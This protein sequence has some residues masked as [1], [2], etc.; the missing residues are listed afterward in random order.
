M[1]PRKVIFYVTI[2]SLGLAGQSWGQEAKGQPLSLQDCLDLAL[3]RNPLVLSSAERIRAAE[4][5]VSQAKELPQPALTVD[6]DLQPRLFDL[7]D[8]GESY[9]GFSELVEFPGKRHLRGK[10]AG[11]ELDELSSDFDLLKLDLS[12]QVKEAFSGLLLAQEKIKYAQQDLDLAR[13][14][15]DKA[16][17]KYSSGEIAEVEVLRA[18]VE[19]AKAANAVRVAENDRRLA[20][21]GLNFLLARRNYEPLEIRG[22]MKRAFTALDLEDLERR[23][24]AS[25]P[26]L[27]RIQSSIAKEGLKKTQGYLSYWPDFELGISRHRVAGTP[28]TWDL[29]LTVPIPLFFWQPKKG[30][31][32]EAEA[33]R[34]SL[35]REAVHL[36]NAIDLEVEEAYLNA[37]AASDQIKLFEGQVLGQAEEVY[38]AFLFKFQE[39]EIGGIELIDAR[40]S[41]N[42]A[43]RGYAD[44]LYNYRLTIATLEKA[45][46]MPLEGDS[47]D[48]N[49]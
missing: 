6:D 8:S 40:R 37:I 23:A 22:Q 36:K 7:G 15:L 33:N 28:K 14:F 25:R 31:I 4:A 34:A 24:L 32:A 5:R 13:D 16:E 20:A 9:I 1:N 48:A 21:A 43:R 27:R 29:T 35:D 30:V 45:I 26:E 39:G 18:R 2:V 17:S 11:R 49:M 46:G 38:N 3:A 19:A 12:F 44:A 10:I 47:H 42:E 41:L